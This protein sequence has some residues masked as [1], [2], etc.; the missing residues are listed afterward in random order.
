M[1]EER[2]LAKYQPQSPQQRHTSVEHKPSG[3]LTKHQRATVYFKAL[4]YAKSILCSVGFQEEADVGHTGFSIS[5]QG[6][7]LEMV[8]K[9]PPPMAHVTSHESYKYDPEQI[10]AKVT[11]MT[12]GDGKDYVIQVIAT[13]PN[14]WS[15]NPVFIV[16]R[17]DSPDLLKEAFVN[18]LLSARDAL[19]KCP[20]LMQKIQEALKKVNLD[21]ELEKLKAQDDAQALP[22]NSA[23]QLGYSNDREP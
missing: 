8:C 15:A 6:F 22:P 4:R 10:N 12:P 19:R 21:V 13:P 5:M 1:E 17:P 20:H 11:M 2:R 3:P 16:V 9:E 23:K 7:L 14:Q 18:I